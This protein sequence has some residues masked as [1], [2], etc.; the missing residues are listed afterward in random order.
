MKIRKLVL[1]IICIVIVCL[2][3]AFTVAPSVTLGYDANKLHN[4]EVYYSGAEVNGD[5]LTITVDYNSNN[6]NFEVGKPIEV[7]TDSNFTTPLRLTNSK[8]NGASYDYTFKLGNDKSLSKVYIKPPVLYVPTKITSVST[9]LDEGQTLKMSSKDRSYE[10]AGADWFS[11]NALD[12]SEFTEGTYRVK[13]TVDAITKDLPRFPKLCI[14][15]KEV[16]GIASLDFDNNS[17]WKSG[18]FLFDVFAASEQE[19]AAQLASADLTV[20]EALIRVASS[21]LTVSSNVKSLVVAKG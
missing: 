7:T 14:G 5:F 11:I 10:S 8:S 21:D 15:G 20:N 6:K 12:I 13:V 17:V 3:C 16:G 2:I 18:E 4:I 1:V 9:I 19:V